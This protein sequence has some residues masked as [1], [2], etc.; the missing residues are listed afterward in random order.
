M[1]NHKDDMLDL[2]LKHIGE[3]HAYNINK[4]LEKN[5]EAI[6]NIDFPK[7][8]DE[9][10]E[11][12]TKQRYRKQRIKKRMQTL[13]K[14]SARIAAVLV[15]IITILGV[16]TFSVEAF[17]IDFLN[18]FVTEKSNNL[19]IKS[20]RVVQ[21]ED[22]LEDYED[23]Y[24]LGYVPEGFVLSDVEGIKEHL[25]ITYINGNKRIDFMQHF[26]DIDISLDNERMKITYE[27]LKGGEQAIF[28][29]SAD[30]NSI[31][32]ENDIC[33]FVLS[34]EADIKTLKE[35]AESIIWK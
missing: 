18:F 32:W 9:W 35:M 22:L 26:S 14:S 23:L 7:E 33:T 21:G 8:L 16:V 25:L 24:V 30:Y 3:Q 28:S 5:K 4:E 12:F 34:G 13:Y 15:L 10:F 11:N 20:R 17:R 29:Q 6:E 19:E 27:E 1:P 31:V 2:Y